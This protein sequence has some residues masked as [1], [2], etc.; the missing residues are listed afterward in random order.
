MTKDQEE[1][2]WHKRN[3]K[4]NGITLIALVIT[5]VVLLILAGVSI[6]SINSSDSTVQKATEARDDWNN[7]TEK[8]KDR[9]DEVTQ[10]NKKVNPVTD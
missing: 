2:L 4:I 3:K 6:A 8:D 1:K 7:A 5:I 9:I 10:M